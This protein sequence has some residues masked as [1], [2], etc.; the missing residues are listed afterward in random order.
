[1]ESNSDKIIYQ[2][3]VIEFAQVAV[4][5]CAQLEQSAEAERLAFLDTMLKIIPL[6]YMRAQLLPEVESEGDFL[7]EEYVT[8][9]D[10]EYILNNLAA[11][12]G[13]GDMYL[14]VVTDRDMRTDD[15]EWRRVSEHL[16]DA[17]QPL[18]N[19]LAAY[20]NGMEESML[21][22]LWSLRNDFSAYWGEA[23]VDALRQLHRMKFNEDELADEDFEE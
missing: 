3:E 8:E 1:M 11:L 15:T 23:L 4:Q 7:P 12:L 10:Y 2:H 16:T 22:A 5:Y 18:R 6:L 19:F 14:D 17:Y 13:E 9:H 20:Q 21:D